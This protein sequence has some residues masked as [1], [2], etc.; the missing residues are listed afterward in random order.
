MCSQSQ[1]VQKQK[2][3]VCDVLHIIVRGRADPKTWPPPID[4]LQGMATVNQE[5]ASKVDENSW[6]KKIVCSLTPVET[7]N[8]WLNNV[9]MCVSYPCWRWW[10]DLGLRMKILSWTWVRLAIIDTRENKPFLKDLAM[11]CALF[12][13]HLLFCVFFL[14]LVVGFGCVVV[15]KVVSYWCIFSFTILYWIN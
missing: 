12:S 11:S 9:M 10:L 5:R 6:S 8:W 7:Q 15:R 1:T 14:G 2:K 13:L 3:T 4:D